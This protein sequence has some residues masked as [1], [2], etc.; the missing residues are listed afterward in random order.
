MELVTI[1]K[2]VWQCGKLTLY[3]SVIAVCSLVIFDSLPKKFISHTAHEVV[4]EGVEKVKTKKALATYQHSATGGALIAGT[5][6]STGFINSGD[7]KAT[8]GN[9]STTNA[10]GNYWS[11]RR[12]TT[13]GLN[14][15]LYFDN[16]LLYNANKL[17]IAF[18]DANATTASQYIHQI[19]DWVSD[20]NVDNG[21]D[22]ECT[23]G[24]WRTLHPRRSTY[25]N[26]AD[27]TR[28]YEIFDGYFTSRGSIAPGT[29]TPTPL[30]NFVDS[31]NNNR[32]A[33]RTYS[34]STLAYEYRIDYATV[35]VAVDPFYEPASIA[36]TTVGT[37]T[38]Y[39]SDLV[40]AVSTNLTASDGFKMTLPMPAVSTPIDFYYSFKNVETYTGM[41]TILVEPEVCVSNANLKFGMFLWDFTNEQWTSHASSS[42]LAT[43]CTTDVELA[44]SFN[45][46]SVPG[47]VFADHISPTGEIR[48][49]FLSTAPATIYNLQFDKVYI[50]LGSVN[51][52]S[53][54]CEISWGSGTDTDCV[55][56]RDVSDAIT[57]SA[58]TPRWQITDEIEYPATFYGLDNDDDA[59]NGEYA[60]SA[61]LS[62]PITIASSTSVTA[63]HY[64]VK[65]RTGTTTIT[66][67]VQIKDY[68]GTSGLGTEAV[69]SGWTNTP[70]TDTNALTT[71]GWFDTWRLIPQQA[72]P[73]DY[74][75][76]QNNEMNL[77]IRTSA[78]T[79]IAGGITGDWDFA[80]MSIRWI[81]TPVTPST[82]S[83]SFSI[84]DNS[85]GFGVIS[86][87]EGR[88]ATGN[89]A[90][91]TTEVIAHT[92]TASTNAPEGYT[93]TLN[94]N[95]LTCTLCGETTIAPTGA[96]PTTSVPGTEQFGMR[97]RA[98][99][100]SGTTTAPYNS[101][102]YAFDTLNFPDQVGQGAGDNTGTT[103]RVYYLANVTDVTVAGSY[104][105]ILNYT[106]TS[107][108]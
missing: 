82:H 79:N 80:M 75:D 8:I 32:V 77:R 64:A 30:A 31:T 50:M 41:N 6:S 74:V 108:F 83:L 68:A 96:T 51:T 93:I 3:A 26:T 45:S 16:T 46:D 44:F 39:V 49:R 100:G 55:N 25:T 29:T 101:T 72:S 97:M 9:D 1:Q 73:D 19:C 66:Q 61:N 76:T 11:A 106:I 7:W 52:D 84:S 35:E 104:N 91:S 70:G 98:V 38:G 5:A 58:T 78:S 48:L 92:L 17:I 13:N 95:T 36:T 67:D 59:V 14:L 65:Y 102:L 105:A 107:S 15:Q 47:F 54:K 23:G 33:L 57:A 60:R 43:T 27:T 81:E 2:F 89:G 99:S 12:D 20:T 53:S 4:V 56:T 40:G 88:Y 86:S 18:D 103:Y 42:V 10:A 90:G 37:T 34:S 24:G 22:T 87:V 85:V 21:A 28:I 63:I 62:F 69:G 94:G 71:Y